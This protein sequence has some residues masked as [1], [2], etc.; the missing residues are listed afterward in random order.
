MQAPDTENDDDERSDV[1]PGDET[2]IVPFSAAVLNSPALAGRIALRQAHY[3]DWIREHGSSCLRKAERNGAGFKKQLA[4]ERVAH[5]F[6][7][8][9]EAQFATRVLYGR[10]QSE[11]DSP[12]VT[13]TF[14]HVDRLRV[15][16]IFPEDIY[17]AKYIHVDVGKPTARQG[18][19]I[20]LRQT[21]A[22][23]VPRGHLVF[24]FIA[25][26]NDKTGDFEAAQ[27]PF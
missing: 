25:L 20:I 9:Y 10:L 17:E 23:W 8:T 18:A 13:E 1:Q 7:W 4:H 22:P 16:N 24:A 6:G 5:E 15:L 21:S 26:F 2:R 11:E 27:N 19:G 14:W 12:P 3:R